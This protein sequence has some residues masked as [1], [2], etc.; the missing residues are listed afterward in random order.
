MGLFRTYGLAADNDATYSPYQMRLSAK[1]IELLNPSD[2]TTHIEM[3]PS[4]NLGCAINFQAA[5]ARDGATAYTAGQNVWFYH[6]WGST[7][8]LNTINSLSDPTTGPTLPS[9]YTHYAPCFPAVIGASGLL[10]TIRVRGNKAFYQNSPNCILVSNPVYNQKY[11]KDY[12]AYIPTS[13]FSYDCEFAVSGV[14]KSGTYGPQAGVIIQAVDNQNFLNLSIYCPPLTNSANENAMAA[15]MPI[16]ASMTFKYI[17]QKIYTPCDFKDPTWPMLT[18][19]FLSYR[20][21]YG[22]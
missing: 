11:S 14:Y 13:A 5:S 18:V 3:T 10:Q 2:G 15:D 9:G 19:F 12:S 21:P 4:V 1:F 16:D 17:F 8:G 22:G 6:I 20:F 7:P